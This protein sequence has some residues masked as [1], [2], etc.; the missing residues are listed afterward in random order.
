MIALGLRLRYARNRGTTNIGDKMYARPL[1]GAGT[2]AF[3]SSFVV[4][5]AGAS[6]HWILTE[7]GSI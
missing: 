4:S 5:A 6:S 7:L 3:L 1:D 2:A